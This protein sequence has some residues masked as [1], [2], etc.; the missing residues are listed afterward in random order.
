MRKLCCA[1]LLALAAAVPARAN[2]CCICPYKIEAGC[3]AYIRCTPYG[4]APTQ[5]GP[6]Y[7]Y[8]PLEAHFQVP[9]L[10]QFPNWPSP[11]GLPN[12]GGY[13]PAGPGLPPPVVPQPAP[14]GQ[15]TPPMPEAHPSGYLQPAG[16][17]N[18]PQTVPTYWYGR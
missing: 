4:G 2:V 13:P 1:A 11:M 14:P 15:L 8:W 10:P 6:W 18:Y 9:A 12:T 17:Y 16:Y 3:N 5:L 7:L